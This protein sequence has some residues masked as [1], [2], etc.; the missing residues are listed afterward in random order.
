MINK[1]KS[2]Y[3]TT[4]FW[5][6]AIATVA[7]IVMA[8]GIVIPGSETAQV[9]GIVLSTLATLGYTTTRSQTKIGLK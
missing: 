6:S 7:G 4:E 2:G 8:S 1:M 9:L 3:K 5:L